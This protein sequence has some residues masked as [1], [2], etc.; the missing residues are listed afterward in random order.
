V[1]AGLRIMATADDPVAAAPV[2]ATRSVPSFALTVDSPGLLSST[3]LASCRSW[4]RSSPR[5][6]PRRKHHDR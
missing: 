3:P 5:R 1:L 6:S 4:R 2:E